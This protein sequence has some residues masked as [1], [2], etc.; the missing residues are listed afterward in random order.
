MG[1][2]WTFDISFFEVDLSPHFSGLG[3]NNK[4]REAVSRELA[5]KMKRNVMQSLR[6]MLID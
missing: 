2:A 6:S 1:T 4:E 5:V 3:F